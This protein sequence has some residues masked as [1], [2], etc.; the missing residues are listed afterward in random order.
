MFVT[1]IAEKVREWKERQEAIARGEIP[2]DSE[3]VE[4]EVV[5]MVEVN[6]LSG[7]SKFMEIFSIV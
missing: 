3:E 4:E 7:L 1:V 2:K 5:Y 6:I